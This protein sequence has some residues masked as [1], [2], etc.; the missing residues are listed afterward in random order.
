MPP[1]SIAEYI[2]NAELCER[3]A[4]TA[5]SADN[6]ENMQYLALRWRMLASEGEARS[7]LSRSNKLG[8]RRIPPNSGHGNRC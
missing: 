5:S 7:S 6:R 1:I 8:V 2:E 3:I 4:E